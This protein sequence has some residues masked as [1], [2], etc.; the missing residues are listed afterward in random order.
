MF[1]TLFLM[2]GFSSASNL[3]FGIGCRLSLFD[4]AVQEHHTLMSVHVENYPGYPIRQIRAHLVQTVAQGTAGRHSNGPPVLGR[5]YILPHQ[6]SLSSGKII[7]Q[8]FPDR[9]VALLGS[10]KER[11]DSPLPPLR[12]QASNYLAPHSQLACTLQGTP[13]KVNR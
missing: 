12:G 9:L 4:E 10:K 13:V 8:P 11:G 3:H 6:L 5:P 2:H 1:S 7:L